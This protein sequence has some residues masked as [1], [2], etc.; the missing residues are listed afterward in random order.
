MHV[1]LLEI[2]Y[3]SENRE[4]VETWLSRADLGGVIISTEQYDD[5]VLAVLASEQ[6]LGE[7]LQQV[8]QQPAISSYEEKRRAIYRF[9]TT[10]TP[11]HVLCS[12]PFHNGEEW[13]LGSGN[14][15]YLCMPADQF[16]CIQVSWLAHS[17]DIDEW[18][19]V[20]DLVPV[21]T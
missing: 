11:E 19:P 9:T 7:A 16:N 3:A 5:E 15:A 14:V 21:L 1:H 2:V 4:T 20:F 18:C 10:I 8:R 6:S 17:T 13:Y 12:F